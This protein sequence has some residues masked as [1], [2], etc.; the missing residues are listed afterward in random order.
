MTKVADLHGAWSKD[1]EY[2]AEYDRVGPEFALA[3]AHRGAHAGASHPGGARR[4]H[5]ND[6]I[7]GGPAGERAR[8]PLHA[9]AG[10]GGAGDRDPAPHPL[11]SGVSRRAAGQAPIGGGDSPGRQCRERG[12][13]SDGTRKPQ[14]ALLLDPRS[15]GTSFFEA[16][17]RLREGKTLVVRY[18]RGHPR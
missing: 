12:D 17:R 6:P 15:E 11:R 10:E 4:A 8:V 18:W 2:L 3:R 16:V 5:G 7:G 13:R 9:D 1:P 14:R